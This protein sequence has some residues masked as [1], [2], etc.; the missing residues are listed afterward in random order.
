MNLIVGMP[1]GNEMQIIQ[2]INLFRH[3]FNSYLCIINNIITKW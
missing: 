3:D 2:L 1:D